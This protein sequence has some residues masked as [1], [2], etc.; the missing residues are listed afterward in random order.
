MEKKD[1]RQT[2][3]SPLLFACAESAGLLFLAQLGMLPFNLIAPELGRRQGIRLAPLEQV[4]VYLGK[5]ACRHATF[6]PN[7]SLRS[8]EGHVRRPRFG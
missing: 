3:V 7:T 4:G 6:P 2:P 5:T 8:K 1:S